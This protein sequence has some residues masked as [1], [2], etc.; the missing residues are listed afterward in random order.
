MACRNNIL[1]IVGGVDYCSR[2]RLLL[3]TMAEEEFQQAEK[4]HHIQISDTFQIY[5]LIPGL[6]LLA[7][8]GK[9]V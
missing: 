9:I 7:V 1:S 2:S 8:L 5:I 6:L 3:V 4:P